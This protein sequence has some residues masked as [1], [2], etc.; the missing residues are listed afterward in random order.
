M[1]NAMQ[2]TRDTVATL[3]RMAKTTDDPNVAAGLVAKA[4]DLKDRLD[5]LSPSKGSPA[6]PHVPAKQVR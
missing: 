6:P 4:A 2:L 1:W 5:N 3:L